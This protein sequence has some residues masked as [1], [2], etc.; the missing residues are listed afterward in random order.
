MSN[1]E[2]LKKIN[3]NDK[4]EKK[5]RFT[6]LSWAWAVETLLTHDPLATWHY[7]EPMTLPDG[8]MLVFCSVTAYGKEMTMQM[9]VIDHN[10]KPIKIPNSFDVNTAMQRCLVKAIALHGLGLYIYAG[11]DLP[12]DD[13]GNA[14]SRPKETPK[15]NILADTTKEMK[16]LND[17]AKRGTAAL[18]KAWSGLTEE[19]RETLKDKLASLKEAAAMI[20]EDI[21]NQP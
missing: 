18:R 12:E 20:D 8:S 15:G 11:E 5:G 16:L 17:A 3:V 13:D 2:T 10:N 14:G 9:P 19:A 1:F 7:N 6:Y 21:A 4:T